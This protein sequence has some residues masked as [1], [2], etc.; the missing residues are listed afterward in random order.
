M[1]Q[2]MQKR[3][4]KKTKNTPGRDK[5]ALTDQQK[6]AVKLLINGARVSEV[7]AALHVHR[8]TLWRW[9]QNP[10]LRNYAKRYYDREIHKILEQPIKDPLFNGLDSPNPWE[11][12][13][14]AVKIIDRGQWAIMG[15]GK[16]PF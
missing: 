14:T 3:P 10:Q 11:V 6:A 15:I 2:S 4:I 13:R 12:E 9:F 8:T 1:N 5:K 16:P 7:A